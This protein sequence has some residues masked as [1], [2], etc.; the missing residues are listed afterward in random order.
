MI[1]NQF[2]SRNIVLGNPYGLQPGNQKT[3]VTTNSGLRTGPMIRSSIAQT[4]MQ[5][6]QSHLI[7]QG[8]H[9]SQRVSVERNSSGIRP[10]F[11]I[12][13]VVPGFLVSVHGER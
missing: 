9:V 1:Q 7:Q 4:N 10:S 8:S 6:T 12:N 5:N 3:V 2:N 13:L 11:D